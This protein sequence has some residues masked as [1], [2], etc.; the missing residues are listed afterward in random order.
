MDDATKLVWGFDKAPSLLAGIILSFNQGQQETDEGLKRNAFFVRERI[1]IWIAGVGYVIFSIISIIAIPLMFHEVKWYY[2]V[3]TY[4]LAPAI[5][6]CNAYGASLTNMNMGYNYGKV[7]L[8]VIAAMAG[9]HSGVVAGHIRCGLIKSIISICSYL[10]HDFKTGHLTLISPRSMLVSQAIGT[11]MGCIAPLTFLLSYNAFDVDNPNGEYKAPYALIYRNMAILGVQG[12]SALPQHCLQLCYGFFGF[13]MASNLVR[14]F[15]PKPIAKCIHL[16]TAMAVPFLVEAYFAIGMCVVA[17]CE[18][19]HIIELDYQRLFFIMSTT[20]ELYPGYIGVGQRKKLEIFW[21]VVIT[22]DIKSNLFAKWFS[23]VQLAC[24][25]VVKLIFV[26]RIYTRAKFHLKFL[27]LAGFK[28][29]VFAT[30]VATQAHQLSPYISKTYFIILLNL[31]VMG[32]GI[33]SVSDVLD[34][35]TEKL[36]LSKCVEELILEYLSFVKG[37]ISS[38][39]L[40]LNF[41]SAMLKHDKIYKQVTYMADVFDEYDTGQLKEYEVA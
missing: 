23:Q 34:G 13:S 25:N 15:S 37:S 11:A 32:M 39:E 16:P 22:Y 3:V 4:L 27:V 20:N 29:E 33:R 24:T 8:F 2:V 10:T 28:R 41:S 35:L 19:H 7:A 14:D 30:Q 17:R 6:F 26:S 9:N 1:P 36:E 18:I 21:C 31:A 5:G 12:F 40:S 38:E